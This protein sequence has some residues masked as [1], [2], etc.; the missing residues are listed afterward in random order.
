MTGNQINRSKKRKTALKHGFRSGLEDDFYQF[1]MGI[2][3]KDKHHTLL[4]ESKEC[5]VKYVVPEETHKYTPDFVFSTAKNII[6]ETKGLFSAQDRKKHLLVREQ[7]PEL[8]VR[9]IFYNANQRLTRTSKTRYRDWCD[10]NGFK[11]CAWADRV[12]VEQW[13]KEASVGNLD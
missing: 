13:I 4:Y 3:P 10:K 7:H 12:T 5:V 6:L 2:L 11:W 1:A 8:D 9:F